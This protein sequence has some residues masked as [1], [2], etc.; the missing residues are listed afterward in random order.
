MPQTPPL[1]LLVPSGRQLLSLL[2]RRYHQRRLLLRLHLQHPQHSQLLQLHHKRCPSPKLLLACS[3]SS[4]QWPSSRLV[5]PPPAAAHLRSLVRAWHQCAESLLLCQ[6]S[7]K[8]QQQ[9]QNEHSGSSSDGGKDEGEKQKQDENEKNNEF[10]TRM[11]LLLLAQWIVMAMFSSHW[12][13]RLAASIRATSP[14]R[15]LLSWQDACA[16]LAAGEVSSIVLRS[17]LGLA[18]LQLQPGA[19]LAGEPVEPGTS[20]LLCL[21]R[22]VASKVGQL[23]GLSPEAM[24]DFLSRSKFF[25]ES[26]PSAEFKRELRKLEAKLLVPESEQ[27]ELQESQ[28]PGDPNFLMLMLVLANL[29]TLAA[30]FS[31]RRRRPPAVPSRGGSASESRKSNNGGPLNDLLS[32]LDPFNLRAVSPSARITS[33]VRFKDVAGLHEAKQELEEFVSYLKDPKR[34]QTLGARLPHG[35]LLLG[36]PGCGKTLLVKALANEA[37]V[38]FF[39]M[40]GPEFVEVIG[41]LG[42]S[43]VR[44]LFEQARESAPC[45]IFI[46]ELDA[47]GKKRSGSAGSDT[48]GQGE[49]DQTLN[50]LLVEMDGMDTT[51]GV[52]CFAATNRHEVLD[53]A[54]L[55]AGRFDRHILVDLPTLI[56]RQELFALYLGQYKLAALPANFNKRLAALTPGR[57]GADIANVC[58]EAA[59]IAARHA[60]SAVEAA[61]FEAALERAAAQKPARPAPMTKEERERTAY[62]E[63]GKALVAWMLETPP[64]VVRV[65]IVRRRGGAGAG[66]QRLSTDRKLYTRQALLEAIACMLAGRAA[67]T[68]AFNT[69][70]S[71]GSDEQRAAT[72]LAYRLV[73]ELG[74][75]DRIGHL[76]FDQE[77]ASVNSPVRPFS[78]RTEALFD[79]EAQAVLGQ[80]FRLA[81]EVLASNRGRLDRV[82]RALLA[83]EEL[84]HEQLLELL[85]TSPHPKP[86]LAEL[87]DLAKD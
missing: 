71:G 73:R 12:S 37:S 53:T 35:A 22:S 63:A 11:M 60:K 26:A 74:M 36:P 47:I 69:V 49:M 85:G 7:Q 56:E 33:Q 9:K 52:V 64:P 15:L 42:A 55:R 31:S 17:D 25:S 57:S 44:R 51:V 68:V 1:K 54:L 34:F 5:A 40:A 24:R 3:L 72:D 61:D 20:A 41:G 75:S 48:G 76:S 8:Q 59:L 45:I 43:R 27:V 6:D 39:Y 30:V 2:C 83:K 21:N 79:S 28:G 65:S 70:S 78:R 16:L 82:A 29:L 32:K 66:L 58:N 18:Q 81:R 87:L 38:P 19:L 10:T 23:L 67:E 13:D 46:D 50:Q 80:A 4:C 62:S 77:S 84:G 14:P 86:E